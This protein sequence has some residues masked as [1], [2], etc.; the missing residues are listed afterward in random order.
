MSILKNGVYMKYMFCYP[1]NTQTIQ[2]ILSR[3]KIMLVKGSTAPTSYIPYGVK[4]PVKKTVNGIDTT[5]NIYLTAP[6]NKISTYKDSINSS[7]AL[8]RNIGVKVFDGTESFVSSG[9]LDNCWTC[10]T[11][12][13][14]D[15]SFTDRTVLC[16]HF[17]HSSTLPAGTGRQG[18]A[19]LGK[20]TSSGG[21]N[22]A[23]KYVGFGAV[24]DYPTL[25]E[26][27]AWLAEQY[28]NG[29][30]VCCFYPLATSTT[31]QIEVPTITTARG[32]NILAVETEIK[33]SNMSVVYRKRTE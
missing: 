8:T 32:N 17:K 14:S 9:I 2:K 23:G 18:Y 11:R 33:P 3:F 31:T 5:Y 24:T 12:L 29:T 7:G 4:V 16:S 10:T 15:T 30:P 22:P 6:L 20:V 1:N 26:W 19:L 28:A 25:A 21:Q 13:D 27:K